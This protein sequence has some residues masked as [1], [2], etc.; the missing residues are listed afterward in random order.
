MGL[1]QVV[2]LDL[3]VQGTLRE[4]QESNIGREKQPIKNE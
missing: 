3:E 2:Y 4:K 1:G